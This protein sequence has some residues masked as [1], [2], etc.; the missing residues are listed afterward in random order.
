M[1]RVAALVLSHNDEATIGAAVTSI[2]RSARREELVGLFVADDGS[3]DNTVA[4]AK[5]SAGAFPIEIIAAPSNVGQWPNLNRALEH[6]NER[7]DWILL[8]HADD[9][10]LEGWLESMFERID[11]CADNVAS[12]SSSWDML[13]GEQVDPTGENHHD[14]VRIIAGST[15]AVHD[16]LLRGCW[17]KISGAAIRL[18]AFGDIGP[19]DATVPHCG[20][21]D[22]LM[23]GLARGWS[24]EYLPRVYLRYRQHA[25][26][27]SSA[28]FREDVEITDAM[29][30]ADRFGR[31]LSSSDVIRFHAKRGYFV[32]RRLGR[33]VLRRDLHR[34]AVSFR[35][36]RMLGRH[37]VKQLA[38]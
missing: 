29:T 3:R 12:I 19:F 25:K 35:T 5:R 26:T 18:R 36:W 37:L 21:W 14:P 2:L 28:S 33:A 10:V 22:W 27:V 32:M 8:L 24:F 9:L 17:W 4:A 7:A 23:R 20:D 16:T 30:M 1:T 38:S 11:R 31:T 34:I 13:Y 6:L 15:E